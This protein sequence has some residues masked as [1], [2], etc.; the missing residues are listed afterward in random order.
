MKDLV[1]LVVDSALMIFSLGI[2]KSTCLI[3]VTIFAAFFLLCLV[4]FNIATSKYN[5]IYNTVV[6]LDFRGELEKDQ[7]IKFS[8]QA[9]VLNLRSMLSFYAM[10]AS[11]IAI[12]LLV[13]TFISK[14]L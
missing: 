7:K 13:L 3:L 4:L 14:I 10:A 8:N 2:S 12:C 5:K 11:G 9:Y 1:S 6:D